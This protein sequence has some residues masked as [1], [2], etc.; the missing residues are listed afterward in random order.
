VTALDAFLKLFPMMLELRALSASGRYAELHETAT[1]AL[2]VFAQDGERTE[3]LTAMRPLLVE[4]AGAA[5]Q[6]LERYDEALDR[7]D[8]SV[9]FWAASPGHPRGH[10]RA[11]LHRAIAL[12]GLGRFADAEADY[13]EAL[14]IV[15]ES[16][17]DDVAAVRRLA[18]AH[19]ADMTAARGETGSDA[20]IADL[21]WEGPWPEGGGA[22]G[23]LAERNA[24]GALAL[25]AGR[26]DEAIELLQ[27]ADRDAAA[28]PDARIRGA[29]ASN[30]GAAYVRAGRVQEGIEQ[31][32]AASDA[33][34]DCGAMRMLAMDEYNLGE[35]TFADGDREAA[36][37]HLRSAWDAVRK[38]STRS[39]LAMRILRT[40]ALTRLAERDMTRARSAAARGIEIYD[41]LRSDLARDEHAHAGALDIARD[42]LFVLLHVALEDRWID[43]TAALMEAGKA[44]F[45]LD[46]LRRSRA[47]D[48]G[49]VPQ[50]VAAAGSMARMAEAVGYDTLILMYFVTSGMLFAV[51]SY[52]GVTGH[53]R[54]Q[55][56]PGELETLVDERRFELMGTQGRTSPGDAAG[57]RLANLLLGQVPDGIDPRLV[58]VMPDG[59]LWALPFEDLPVPP[60]GASTRLGERAPVMICPS[61]QVL[62]QL[63]QREHDERPWRPL[64]VGHPLVGAPLPGTL[65]QLAAIRRAVRGRCRGGWWLWGATATR[66]R[67]LA[68]MEHATHIHIAAHAVGSIEDA[69]P[70]ILLG[71]ENAAPDP[72]QL[73]DVE[74][75]RLQADLVTLS[76]CSTMLGI[77]STGEGMMSLARAF[78]FA[79]ARCVIGT[80]WEIADEDAVPLMRRFYEE[81]AA[82]ATAASALQTARDDARRSGMQPRSWT[83]FQL[84]G[85]G[86]SWRSRARMAA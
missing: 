5:A 82:G 67:V 62:E 40:L 74:P 85:D 22:Q 84:V 76:A 26:V 63:Q 3:V 57:A 24:K 61:L 47:S 75:L 77:E 43:Q 17:G 25:A 16:S 46:V 81:L 39:V 80:L 27:A 31:L 60:W 34:R 49:V 33:H 37:S 68:A 35:I 71:T 19:L 8:E 38:G 86:D 10:A 83:A 11:L 72:L 55:V 79:G 70:Y 56:P 15:D 9:R 54:V 51:H 45:W 30:L 44:R 2:A 6:A 29:I 28:H 23:R 69:A 64:V 13:R 18:H 36:V 52:N 59:P 32:E 78:I 50:P 12:E 41:E 20:A 66:A 42:L 1:R 21:A 4:Y 73:T 14:A 53:R 7:F 58:L 65:R 48:D